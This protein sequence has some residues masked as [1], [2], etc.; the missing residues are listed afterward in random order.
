MGAQQKTLVILIAAALFTTQSCSP[1]GRSYRYR[2]TIEVETL[3]GLRTGAA[4]REITYQ[5][6]LKLADSSG[7][8]VTQQGEAVA[9]DLPGGRTMF[10]LLESDPYIT[11][12][13]AFGADSR[14]ILDSAQAD[15]RLAVVKPYPPTIGT[16]PRAP[17]NYYHGYPQ[18][19]TFE[20]IKNPSTVKMVD[21]GH[22]EK[23]FGR[24]VKLRRITVRMTKEAIT[25][26]IVK[27]LPW[28][29]DYQIRQ[30]NL[31]NT[32]NSSVASNELADRLGTGYFQILN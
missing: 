23:T 12:Q 4:V 17:S 13:T 2:M 8:H 18:L 6:A 28:L 21:P 10:A 16:D 15:M 29:E 27:R 7:A 22:L 9:V 5:E 26:E 3:E 32:P 14:A 30:V 1:F 11:M 20:D 19:V 25:Q 24:G 31:N